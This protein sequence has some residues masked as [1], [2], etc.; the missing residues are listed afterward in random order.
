VKKAEARGGRTGGRNSKKRG[1]A[2][3][4]KTTRLPQSKKG[5]VGVKNP[6]SHG[7]RG[8]KRF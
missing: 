3:K 1:L 6:L 2:E 8:N 5:N 4:Q 7:R